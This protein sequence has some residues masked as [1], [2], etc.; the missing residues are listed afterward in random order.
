VPEALD[1]VIIKSLAKDREARYQ[2]AA[3]FRADLE[4]IQHGGRVL[5]PPVGATLPAVA[6]M[7]GA[8]QLMAPATSATSVL[9]P[10]QTPWG[11]TG[12]TG[13]DPAEADEEPKNRRWLLITLIAV[14]VLAAAA[15]VFLLLSQ[16]SQS[17]NV[18]VPDVASKTV[19][20]AEAAL[21]AQGFVPERAQKA[22]PTVAVDLVI[23]TNPAA[24]K[25][26]PR[27]STVTYYVSTGPAT[28]S[29]PDVAGK[30]P[31]Q[32]ITMLQAANLKVSENRENDDNPNFP[33]GQVTKTD[34]EANTPVTEGTVVTLFI[35][36][37]R[38][39]VSDVTNKSQ[40]DAVAELQALKLVPV[41]QTQD[42]TTVPAG[43]VISTTPGAG[44]LLDQ[45][46]SITVLVASAPPQAVV[47][48]GLV[49]LPYDQA[50]TQLTA[51]KLTNVTRVDAPS[52]V[53]PKGS[54]ISVSPT[55]GTTVPLAQQI[56]VTV[57]TGKASPTSTPTP[58]TTP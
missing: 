16:S 48:D 33:K 39:Q 52:D 12:I 30:T 34:P 53:Q 27:G 26:A 20:Q 13:A 40:A 4:A 55:S 42:S 57:S 17:A 24:G 5:A 6:A 21:K 50:L 29:V 9:P 56:T 3:E 47:P 38:V 54:V 10:A 51:A 18:T 58:T 32:A 15:I 37:G 36:T 41:V 45:G 49:G 31:E 44:T 22:D 43:T 8:T 11:A 19:A 35:S 46:A 14:G 1:R 7:T 2:T 28:A 23:G 25:Q